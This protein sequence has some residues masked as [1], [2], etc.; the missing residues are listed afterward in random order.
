MLNH[1]C[2]TWYE[3]YTLNG[4]LTLYMASM[5]TFSV[6]LGLMAITKESLKLRHKF[7]T[8]LTIINV[9]NL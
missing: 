9:Y 2:K 8:E 4:T 1:C 7:G 5:Q 3:C 6:A